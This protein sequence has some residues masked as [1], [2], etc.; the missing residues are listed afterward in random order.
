M[1]LYEIRGLG[2]LIDRQVRVWAEGRAA[3]RAETTHV[4]PVVTLSRQYGAL[5]SELAGRVAARLGYSCWDQELV[6]ELAEQAHAPAALLASLD[7]HA[8]SEVAERIAVFGPGRHV[9]ASEYMTALVQV[10]HT[11]AAHGRA[12]IVGRGSQY[13]VPD[14]INLRVR[15]VAALDDRIARVIE[16]HRIGPA[17]AAERIA[18]IDRERREFTRESYGRD[19]DDP[20]GY[21]L[22]VNTSALPLEAAAQVV[23]AAHDGKFGATRGG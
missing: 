18:T 10:V 11:I 22:V 15:V 7:E 13:L 5:G 20:I 23:A 2:A 19:V 21:D 8:R 12:V 6:H 17:E 14:P 3:A 4:A 1:S 9:T 16:R